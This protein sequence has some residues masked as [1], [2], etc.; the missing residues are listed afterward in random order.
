M[1]LVGVDCIYWINLDR[2]KERKKYME[3]VLSDEVFNG[4]PTQR[5]SAFDAKKGNI[6]KKFVLT[7]DIASRNNFVTPQEYSCLY[8]HLEAIRAFSNTDQE[9]AL[10]F[11]DD[12]SL[13]YKK[14]WTKSIQQVMDDAP[15]DWEVIKLCMR[16]L[17][18]KVFNVYTPWVPTQVEKKKTKCGLTNGWTADWSAVA[19]L[20]RKK[21]AEKL[22]KNLYHVHKYVLDNT[23]FHVSETIIFQ[24]LKT[25]V[26]KYPYFTVRD[27]N[28][29]FI[30]GQTNNYAEVPSKKITLSKYKKMFQTKKNKHKLNN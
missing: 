9:T 6:H 11:E 20:I 8:S 30:Q 18:S 29:S 22:M 3:K 25:Y 12:L 28:N 21:G 16:G 2:A 7:P 23:L 15:K 19:Y 17:A 4:I 24:G 13:E 26:Y 1:S 27:N 14:Y 10:I 5:I